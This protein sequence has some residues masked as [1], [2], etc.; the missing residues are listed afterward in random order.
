MGERGYVE[1]DGGRLYYERDGDGPAVLMIHGGL[2][3]DLRMWEPQVEALSRDF[4]VVRFD[5]RGYGRSADPPNFAYRHCDDAR[6][7]LEHLGV[8]RA[9]VV[10]NSFG[11][12]VAVD[13]AFAHP[14]LVRALVLAPLAPLLGWEWVEGHLVGPVLEAAQTSGP[15]AAISA[16]R[17]LPFFRRGLADPDVG[18]RI[19]RMYADYSGWHFRHRDPARFA[20]P[21]A[22]EHLGR[23]AA[24]TLLIAGEHDARDVH[25]IHELLAEQLPDAERHTIAAAGHVANLEAPGAFD[26]A[27]ERFLA[28]P[29]LAA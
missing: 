3:L 13:L 23:I 6:S 28:D 15:D 14:T 26:D 25:L 7:V 2:F 12:T 19:E 17:D 16:I 11:A 18:P 29:R 22:R 4:S 8:D 27:L 21:D 9:A 10:G 1:V 5:L 20:V 24:P